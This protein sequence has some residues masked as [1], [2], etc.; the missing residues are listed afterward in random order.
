MG[1]R[2][3]GL[4]CAPL[5][6]KSEKLCGGN[7]ASRRTSANFCAMVGVSLDGFSAPGAGKKSARI[8]P[9]LQNLALRC[10]GHG[11][12][13]SSAREHDTLNHRQAGAA[14]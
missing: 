11:A 13:P 4:T 14:W 5:P 12:A 8:N 6:V 7:P 2:L 9:V 10:V 3:P 1:L